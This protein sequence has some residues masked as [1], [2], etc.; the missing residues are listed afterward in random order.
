[1]SEIVDL[2]GQMVGNEAKNEE[3]RRERFGGG[4]GDRYMPMFPWH[5]TRD[6][7]KAGSKNGRT[8]IRLF[9]SLHTV[10][11]ED[12]ALRKLLGY[13][14]DLLGL[15]E[16]HIGKTVKIIV[17]PVVVYTRS[18][19]KPQRYIGLGF[20][21]G[22][23]PDGKGGFVEDYICPFYR[24]L[25]AKKSNMKPAL[26]WAA[27]AMPTRPE[28]IEKGIMPVFLR[29]EWDGRYEKKSLKCYGIRHL[30]YG[31]DPK[32]DQQNGDA[33]VEDADGVIRVAD[34]SLPVFKGLGDSL[35][36]PKG[37]DFVVYKNVELFF[38]GT[39]EGLA[40]DLSVKKPLS[41]L[42]L[43]QPGQPDGMLPS[44]IL[45]APKE[46]SV[47]FPDSILSG[48]TDLFADFRLQPGYA[49]DGNH[50]FNQIPGSA[51]PGDS[52]AKSPVAGEDRTGVKVK[53]ESG[54]VTYV[55]KVKVYGPQKTV[56]ALKVIEQESGPAAANVIKLL[57][58]KH[59][60]PSDPETA[61]AEVESGKLQF[62]K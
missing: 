24:A 19:D 41:A 49:S 37:R 1:M 20:N 47:E 5:P 3:A 27:N 25:K 16:A 62:Q 33:G 45:V 8:T 38:G 56:V 30:I 13:P 14:Y 7:K 4:G 32:T 17:S 42:G 23:I 48:V 11:A 52:A 31:Y 51:T 12:V 60:E 18:G 29:T 35:I 43:L 59:F 34:A 28:D 55:G 21:K 39:K 9:H 40:L 44:P 36:G 26:F 50:F 46:H 57:A 22:M 6:E 53:W 54:G 15:S 10:T 61:L 58:D 2:A